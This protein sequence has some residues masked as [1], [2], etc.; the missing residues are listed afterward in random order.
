MTIADRI[1]A[2]VREHDGCRPTEVFEALGITDDEE[3]EFRAT[4]C[5]LILSRLIRMRYEDMVWS[6]VIYLHVT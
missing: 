1:L 2:Y 6:D 5:A 3:H 4:M